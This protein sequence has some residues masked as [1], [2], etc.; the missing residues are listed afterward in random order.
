MLLPRDVGRPQRLSSGGLAAAQ[1]RPPPGPPGTRPVSAVS[2][3]TPISQNQLPLRS[4]CLV[5][6][7]QHSSASSVTGSRPSCSVSGSFQPRPVTPGAQDEKVRVAVRCRPPNPTQGEDR[8]DVIVSMN[9]SANEVCLLD[10]EATP[11]R[12]DMPLWSC[13]GMARDGSPAVSQASTYEALGRP[14]LRHALEG[15]NSTLMAYGQTGSGK[16]YT[17]MGDHRDGQDGDGAGIIP[18]MCRELFHELNSRSATA[19]GGA[20]ISWEVHVRYVEVYCEKISDLLNC[21]ASVGIREEITPQSATFALVG[22]RRIKVAATDDLLQAL[23]MGNKWRRTAATKLND[24]S[25]RSHAI[26][27][28]DLTEVISFTEPDGTVASAPS[29]NLTIRLVDLAGS[30]RVSETGVHGQQLT[31]VKNINLSLFA[32]G[33]VIECLSDPK[34]RGIKP[35]YRDSVL[36]KLLRDAFGGNSKTTMICTIAPCEAHRC[37]TVQTLH[38]AAKARHVM[39]RPRVKEDPSALEL[40]RANEELAALR[41]QLEDA[42]R[43]GNH[44]DSIEAELKEAN[45]RLRREQKDARLRRQVMERREAE[46]AA[47]LRELEDQR[48]AYEAQMHALEVEAERARAQQERREGEL[49]RAHEAAADYARDRLKEMEGQRVSAEVALRAKEEEL[50]QRQR[51]IE[52][53]M[54][55]A[56]AASR[57]RIDDLQ[58]QQKEMEKALQEKE[59]LASMQEGE[60]RRRCDR[61]E[62]EV[63]SMEQRNAKVGEEWAAKVTALEAAARQRE[64][65]V[66]RRIREAQ[67][68]QSK[69][70]AAARS[71]EEELQRQWAQAEADARRLQTAASAKEAELERRMQEASRRAERREEELDARLRMAEQ[72]L[73]QRERQT[74]Q[75]LVEVEALRQAAELQSETTRAKERTIEDAH[76]ARAESLHAL[77]GQL[78]QREE[79]LRR[80]FEEVMQMK[81]EWT[82][83]HAGLQQKAHAEHDAAMRG[84]REREAELAQR[85]AETRR[86]NDELAGKLRAREMQLEK[87]QMEV[88]AEKNELETAMQQE[89][90]AMLRAREEM[91]LAQDRREVDWK[92]RQD[93]VR[94]SE[95]EVRDRRAE[96]EAAQKDREAALRQK[97]AALVALQDATMAKELQLYQSQER[98]KA[99][100]ADLQRRAAAAKVERGQLQAKFIAGLQRVDMRLGDGDGDAV[101]M[102]AELNATLGHAS[103]SPDALNVREQRYFY[104]F[105]SMY[106]ANILA[107]ARTEFHGLI[108]HNQLEVRDIERCAEVVRMQEVASALQAQLDAARGESISAASRA[109]VSQGQVET[110]S[111]E[112]EHLRRQTVEVR[113]QMGSAVSAAKFAEAQVRQLRIE[114]YEADTRHRGREQDCQAAMLEAQGAAAGA[115]RSHGSLHQLALRILE[116]CEETQRSMLEHHQTSEHQSLQLLRIADRRVLDREGTIRKWQSLYRRRG[117]DDTSARARDDAARQQRVDEE[118]Q[119]LRSLQ[120]NGETL[121]RQEDCLVAERERFEQRVVDFESYQRAQTAELSRQEQEVKKYLLELEEMDQRKMR[122]YAERERHLVEIAEHLKTRQAH[123]RTNAQDLFQSLLQRSVEQQSA[124]AEAQEELERVSVQRAR[125]MERERELIGQAQH[126]N[127]A[128]MH[129]LLRLHEEYVETEKKQLKRRARR[130]EKEEA[131][132][133]QR[134]AEQ[135]AEIHRYLLEIEAED[136]RRTALSQQGQALMREAEARL[137]KAQ[138]KEAAMRDLARQIHLEAMESEDQARTMATTLR[139]EEQST[140]ETLKHRKV[141]LEQRQRAA[142]SAAEYTERTLLDMEADLLAIVNKNKDAEHVIHTREAEIKRQK[143]YYMDLSKMLAE[144]DEMLR[145]EHALRLCGKKNAGSLA[146]D[147]LDVNDALRKQVATWKQKFDVLLAEGKVECERCS[148]KNKKDTTMCMCCGHSGLL[149]LSKA[150]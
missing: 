120:R 13:V 55:A 63:R 31:E 132:S 35:P 66:A 89:R 8:E 38:Y 124:L 67:A 12:V 109:A 32:L 68:A 114:A 143:H 113:V 24:R 1:P 57:T 149:D 142:S 15:Y 82:E 4:L 65:D 28:I 48:E 121:S 147:L 140:R 29:K 138:F 123:I 19:A 102:S 85:E 43:T 91:Q 7:P 22:A 44:Y 130:L 84:V 103:L 30:E 9:P 37:H 47:R 40:R 60:M 75:R 70:E 88:L 27:A 2:P 119:R 148:W 49:R 39:N 50:V 18:R 33:C 95:A 17:M 26:F 83:Q 108:R 136:M 20:R 100:Q 80:Q 25:S 77:E 64:E 141:E 126:G 42:Q 90:R 79:A 76:A 5:P 3:L 23:T 98:L 127:A 94:E 61:A 129:E 81:R 71:R 36:T 106:R 59:R 86:E 16:T 54:R 53:R 128:A 105:E 122:E 73:T 97:E 34:R 107:E 93:K 150:H 133:K 58:R 111:D 118:A 41:Q 92:M 115:S 137:S 110:L 14:L 62:E 116:S 131:R 51:A 78:R 72:E 56:E 134:L 21:G 96:M 125:Y 146:A 74:A 69:A 87:Q 104:A 135:E 139:R 11:W 144:R 6:P 117:E 112:L 46:L 10:Q 99:G 45:S 101:C 52:E 145:K